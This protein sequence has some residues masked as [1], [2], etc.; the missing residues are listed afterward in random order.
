MLAFVRSRFRAP[1]FQQAGISVGLALLVFVA[2][3]VGIYSRM[4]GTLAA[5]WP[6]N[7]LLLGLLVRFPSAASVS[8]WLAA[9][10][11]Y[12]AADLATGSTLVKA[13]LLNSANLVGVVV[14]Y[15]LVRRIATGD[16]RLGNMRSVGWLAALATTS[17]A[18]AAVVGGV[19]QMVLFRDPFWP[20]WLGWYSEEVLNY[21]VILPIIFTFPS[22]LVVR[23]RR[24]DVRRLVLPTVFLL[25]SA[26]P[27][28]L[29][30]GFGTV[31]FSAPALITV[32]LL[33]SVF[34]TTL[35]LAVAAAWS[36]ILIVHHGADMA[37]AT[38]I[39]IAPSAMIGLAMLGFAP[40]TI[41]A[42]TAER[43]RAYRVLR[44][45]MEQD[46]LTGAL[47]RGEF[48]RRGEVALTDGTGRP[49]ALLMMD[50]DHFKRLNDTRGHL[51]GDQA[52]ID[53][54][55]SV[56]EMIGDDALFGRMG[57]EEFALLLPATGRAG[58]VEIAERIR[59][60]QQNHA[61][62]EFDG[63]MATVSIGLA[64]AAGSAVPLSELLV[65]SDEALYRA[66]TNKRNTVVVD[67]IASRD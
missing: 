53:F 65:V 22:R 57:G 36:L 18:A 21:T 52:L 4:P 50:L 40:L 7:A 20:A 13:A 23:M 42:V 54:A 26:V 58:A 59:S 32:A 38:A 39:P 41:A 56:H 61:V 44:T 47:R 35:F 62:A 34:I 46:D 16:L 5:F 30:Q 11:G 25:A 55:A 8:T 51:T 9:A 12:L 43:R 24:T 2:C 19:A 63:V 60:R 3:L 48:L 14:G 17:A 1:W 10:V 15:L 67:E 31:A 29:L 27:A 45:A 6:A 28:W 66:K 49:A 33:S 37:N 64:W